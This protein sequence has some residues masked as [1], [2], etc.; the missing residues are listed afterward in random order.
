MEVFV[1]RL[2]A[3]WR[4]RRLAPESVSIA[5]E[6]TGGDNRPLVFLSHANQAQDVAMAGRI[7]DALTQHAVPVFFD[8]V[9][10]EKQPG[11]PWDSCL[12][13]GIVRC[14]FFVA[15]ISRNALSGEPGR[16][17]H[18][19]WQLANERW[20]GSLRKRPFIVPVVLDDT[21]ASE[22]EFDSLEGFR[23]AQWTPLSDVTAIEEFAVRVKQL[24]RDLQTGASD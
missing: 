24:V 12:K 20:F 6:S 4:Q 22:P 7:Y 11:T 3:Q 8:K 9:E 15:V 2:E 16:Y 21:K 23:E 14:A 17:L 10:L 13:K 5:P 1:D 18:L 19:E